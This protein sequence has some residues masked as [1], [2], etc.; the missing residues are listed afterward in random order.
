MFN[1]SK[2]QSTFRTGLLTQK[3][4]VEWTYWTQH[5]PEQAVRITLQHSLISGKRTLKVNDQTFTSYKR[6]FD[7]GSTDTIPWHDVAFK[8]RI[9]PTYSGGFRYSLDV[10]EQ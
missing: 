10:W 9:R 4:V 2:T 6:F 8:I 7:Y 3:N 1:L 5:Q